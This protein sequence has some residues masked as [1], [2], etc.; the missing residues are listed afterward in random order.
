MPRNSPLNENKKGQI[1]A[2]KLEVLNSCEEL[3]KGP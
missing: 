1:S 2:Y 3:S